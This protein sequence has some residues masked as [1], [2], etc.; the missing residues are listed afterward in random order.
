M[1]TIIFD[2]FS[3]VKLCFDT[4]SVFV[5]S[6][7]SAQ[8]QH[9]PEGRPRAHTSGVHVRSALCSEQKLRFSV[10]CKD[11]SFFSFFKNNLN[12]VSIQNSFK[13]EQSSC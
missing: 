4:V 6:T 3:L 2:V 9:Y 8:C 13:Q 5:F 7:V 12:L 11:E 1:C 10:I